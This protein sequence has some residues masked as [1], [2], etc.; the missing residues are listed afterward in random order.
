VQRSLKRK[1]DDIYDED[2]SIEVL[3][4]HLPALIWWWWWWSY[5]VLGEKKISERNL[6]VSF[7]SFCITTNGWERDEYTVPYGRYRPAGPVLP[8]LSLSLFLSPDGIQYRSSSNKL[9]SRRGKEMMMMLGEWQR[10]KK[11]RVHHCIAMQL[12][13]ITYCMYK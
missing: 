11:K 4:V 7:S 5:C 8:F 1:D 2:S 12:L 9:S 13:E 6:L 10:K 3:L